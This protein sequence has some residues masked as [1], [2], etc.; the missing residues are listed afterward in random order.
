MTT[1][2]SD[3]IVDLRNCAK[4]VNMD[5]CKRCP[6]ATAGCMDAMLEAAADMLKNGAPEDK[7]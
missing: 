6:W 3:L 7:E 2:R 4:S 1:T 5:D